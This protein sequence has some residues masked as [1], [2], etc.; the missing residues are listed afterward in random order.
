MFISL[1]HQHEFILQNQNQK[2]IRNS[3]ELHEAKTQGTAL[4]G[5]LSGDYSS[6]GGLSSLRCDF[7]SLKLYWSRIQ[8]SK[9][10]SKT[11]QNMGFLNWNLWMG[12][13]LK[14]FKSLSID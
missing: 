9:L 6:I 5:D 11:S 1:K 12:S 10:F 8:Y 2:S 13:F 14:D 4:I 7:L 3:L